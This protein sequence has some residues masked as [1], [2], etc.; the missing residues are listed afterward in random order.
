MKLSICKE[1]KVLFLF[2]SDR[3]G[4]SF[5]ELK[6]KNRRKGR[7]VYLQFKISIIKLKVRR[8]LIKKDVFQKILEEKEE[9]IKDCIVL[10]RNEYKPY[11]NLGWICNDL[12]DV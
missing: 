6:H 11:F 2:I 9:A 7:K 1:W 8:T 10:C 12:R 3:N 5:V 4:N